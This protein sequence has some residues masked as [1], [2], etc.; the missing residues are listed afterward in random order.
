MTV[1]IVDDDR[2]VARMLEKF[3]S[4]KGLQVRVEH[5]AGDAWNLLSS[6][7]PPLV[8]L[9]GSR[10]Q[11]ISGAE[12]CRRLRLHA[13]VQ[14]TYLLL[15]TGRFSRREVS[16]GLVADADECITKPF[17]IDHVLERVEYGLHVARERRANKF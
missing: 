14:L 4:A 5:K 7:D 10:L 13:D 3:A 16:A 9:I 11:D 6:D 2:L 15:I 17:R 12:L 8:A 1:L